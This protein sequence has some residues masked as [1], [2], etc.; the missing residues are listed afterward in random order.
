MARLELEGCLAFQGAET[1]R[2]NFIESKG[3]MCIFGAEYCC[4]CG[5]YYLS[6]C[7]GKYDLRARCDY[8]SM[9]YV[10]NSLQ[11]FLDVSEKPMIT[12]VLCG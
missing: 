6:W 5:A 4:E 11:S 1:L 9:V 3:H 7:R 8:F 10:K 2:E 12:C